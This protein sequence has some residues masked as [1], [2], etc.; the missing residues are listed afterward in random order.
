MEFC[1]ERGKR[2]IYLSKSFVGVS[3]AVHTKFVKITRAA[4]PR[5]RHLKL[6]SIVLRTLSDWED[7]LQ[8]MGTKEIVELND[9]ELSDGALPGL[10]QL[11]LQNVS[12]TSIVAHS[13][14]WRMMK[15]KMLSHLTV[16]S[17]NQ[18]KYLLPLYV[19]EDLQQLKTIDIKDCEQL[20]YVFVDEP[21]TQ[22]TTSNVMEVL[23]LLHSLTLFNLPKLALI[24][25]GDAHIN[26]RSFT[27]LTVDSCPKFIFTFVNNLRS[28]KEEEPSKKKSIEMI[29]TPSILENL[30]LRGVDH[31]K[32]MCQ[33]PKVSFEHLTSL[34]LQKCNKLEYLFSLSMAQRLYCLQELRIISCER[35]KQIV[36]RET[37]E[38]GANTIEFLQL[39]TLILQQLPEFTGSY[40]QHGV[41]VRWRA[42]KTVQVTQCSSIQKSMLGTVDRP[43]LNN[44]TVSNCPP[45]GSGNKESDIGYLFELTDQLSKLENL[46]IEDSK[47]LKEYMEMELQESSFAQ[48]KTIEA[49]Q[50]GND[51]NT[52][53]SILLRRSY[54]L[55]RLT[56]KRGVVELRKLVKLEIIECGLRKSPLSTALVEELVLLEELK[57]ESCEM[58][59]QVIEDDTEMQESSFR[60]LKDFQ[61][62]SLPNLIK[63]NSGHC[64]VKFPEL[65]SLTVEKCP[66]LDHVPLN[67]M[68]HPCPKLQKLKMAGLEML[69]DIWQGQDYRIPLCDLKNVEVDSFSKL[70]DMW[71]AK[72]ENL[73]RLVL[74]NCN[75]LGRLVLP[76]NCFNM[77]EIKIS[78][79]NILKEI[80]IEPE[81]QKMDEKT[82][83][84]IE[85]IVLENLP[86]FSFF[87]LETCEFP[88]LRKLRIVNCPTFVN[89]S[90]NKHSELVLFKDI[91]EVSH[92]VKV[93]VFEKLT[94]LK[95]INCGSFKKL[96]SISGAKQLSSLKLLALYGCVDMV[97]VLQGEGETGSQVVFNKLEKL[98]LKHLPKLTSFCEEDVDFGELPELKMVI[99]EEIPNMNTFVKKT[100]R[101]PKLKHVHLTYITKCWLGDL[102]ETIRDLHEK[103][104]ELKNEVWESDQRVTRHQSDT[105]ESSSHQKK[106][107]S[108]AFSPNNIICGL[109]KKSLLHTCI[110]KMH[111]LEITLATHA[112]LKL[113]IHLGEREGTYGVNGSPK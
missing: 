24:C 104:D 19:L 62:A 99:V 54:K 97:H 48:L 60:K 59:E 15:L 35:I 1:R 103:H 6:I 53:L 51:L 90:L 13:S 94:S 47:K 55:E 61:L 46:I 98:V 69:E 22:T 28:I 81:Q 101:T 76:S 109:L 82:I 110:Y 33:D 29:L 89:N 74:R 40:C 83:P 27:Q 25:S 37:E 34:Q 65:L 41:S 92:L 85:Y 44:V 58:I 105:A 31:L 17:C 4:L 71:I 87:A 100:L 91:K 80:C 12:F 50:C 9:A 39:K 7:P 11:C 112:T 113:S 108:L 57:I 68:M 14:S 18:L 5:L 106:V 67:E 21:D 79:C 63:L 23:P 43:L 88:S 26:S 93:L 38:T 49:S 3:F 8:N 52:F 96:F 42:L 20:E 45:W 78:D 84:L 10:Q 30:N 86:K 36:K 75:S 64:N 77:K 72:S 111:F 73:G 2:E 56:I 70:R 102:N 16:G 107:L 66:K 95:I 32:N